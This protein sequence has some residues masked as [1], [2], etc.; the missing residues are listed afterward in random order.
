[1]SVTSTQ[2]LAKIKYDTKECQTAGSKS[3]HYLYLKNI[4]LY[5]YGNEQ[6]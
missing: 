1:M 6:N 2:K 4:D 3:L 5:E